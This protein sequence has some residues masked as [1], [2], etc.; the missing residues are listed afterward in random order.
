MDRHYSTLDRLIASVDE[1]LRLSTGDA[2]APQRSN[3]A[4]DISPAELDEE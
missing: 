3:P 2:P 4:G 1:A